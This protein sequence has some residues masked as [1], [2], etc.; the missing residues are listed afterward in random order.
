M[1]S[2]PSGPPLREYVVGVIPPALT[3]IVNSSSETL[4]SEAEIDRLRKEVEDF[5]TVIRKQ[6]GRYQKD[7][8]SLVARHGTSEQARRRDVLKIAA[9]QEEGA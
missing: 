7:Y 8:E 5:Y 2:T 1:T 6:A 4:P 3:N 9:K